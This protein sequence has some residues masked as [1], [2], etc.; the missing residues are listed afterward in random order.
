M[1]FLNR[2][3]GEL[4][5]QDGLR[6]TAG[7]PVGELAEAISGDGDQMV[8]LGSHAVSG[9]RLIP[10]CMVEGGCV[11]S[12][13]LCV[14]A[15]GG[16]SDVSAEKQRAFLFSRLGLRDPWPETMDSVQIHCPFGETIITTDP[17]TGRSEARILYAAR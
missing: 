12:I 11:Q 4:T 6:L 8:R 3:T 15:I 10:I 16:R 14:S 17:H 5:F 13:S 1:A 2:D 9:G 7:W